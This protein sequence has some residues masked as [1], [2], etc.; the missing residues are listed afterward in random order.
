MNATADQA[1]TAT[2]TVDLGGSSCAIRAQD[3][4]RNTADPNRALWF[5]GVMRHVVAALAGAP[6]AIT[7]DNQTG[8]TEIGVTLVRVSSTLAGSQAVVIRRP[9][10]DETAFPL[11]GIGDT[12]IPLVDP[13]T[14][15]GG[16]KWR[17]LDSHRNETS[18]AIRLAQESYGPSAG[19]AYGRWTAT[20]ERQ[21]VSV[22]YEPS[23]NA[24]AG[25]STGT[26]W[27]GHVQDGRVTSR[28]SD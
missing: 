24:P 22:R 5:A 2:A 20:C 25:V 6:V 9:S 26:R 27:S 13:I 1:A 7:V 10:G 17:A 3:F 12:I 16:A 15:G 4:N 14:A 23:R 19:R 18:D 8:H 11:F 28:S 21:G